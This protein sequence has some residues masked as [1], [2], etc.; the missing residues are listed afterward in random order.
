[1]PPNDTLGTEPSGD[2]LQLLS[3]CHRAMTRL[4]E[5]SNYG[6]LQAMS[7]GSQAETSMPTIP[8]KNTPPYVP[9]GRKAACVRCLHEWSPYVRQPRKCP[10]CQTPWWYQGRWQWARKTRYG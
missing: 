4:L 9:K 8:D 6:Y 1:M 10:K 2:F 7:A 5:E 3:D